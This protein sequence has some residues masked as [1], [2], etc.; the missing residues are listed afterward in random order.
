MIFLKFFK[1]LLCSEWRIDCRSKNGSEDQLEGLVRN[2][3]RL[4]VSAIKE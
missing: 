1:K 3:I 2:L 4:L